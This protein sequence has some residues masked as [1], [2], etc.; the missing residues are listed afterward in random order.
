MSNKA[1]IPQHSLSS[2]ATKGIFIIHLSEYDN[3]NKHQVAEPHRDDHFTIVVM[4]SGLIELKLDFNILNITTPTFLLIRP[5]QIHQLVQMKACKGWL[6]NIDVAALPDDLR[7]DINDYLSTAITLPD[8][9]VVTKNLYSLLEVA[10]ALSSHL[11]NTLLNQ[12]SETSI[13]SVIRLAISL[14]Q[15]DAAIKK[16][17]G[18][19]TVIYRQFMSLLDIHFKSW[20]QASA[21][22]LEMNVSTSH[23]N[24]SVKLISGLSVSFHIQSRVILEA[25]RLLYNTNWTVSEIAFALG[26]E[27]PVYFGKLFRKHT[28]LTPLTFRVKFRE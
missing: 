5:E 14:V 22:A 7:S 26:Y 4:Q 25:K 3:Y 12:V 11:S 10:T 15:S 1:Q 19:S 16:H 2:H 18:R 28:Q 17:T 8:K 6:L 27:D 23:L 21:Y 13:A 24:D 20:K 9:S